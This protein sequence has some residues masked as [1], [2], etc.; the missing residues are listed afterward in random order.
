TT[1]KTRSTT[2]A[3]SVQREYRYWTSESQ[4]TLSCPFTTK[5]L[6]TVDLTR[7][8]RG[9]GWKALQ[10]I[11]GSTVVVLAQ[12]F[13]KNLGDPSATDRLPRGNI[14]GHPC[15]WD[16]PSHSFVSSPT[17]PSPRRRRDESHRSRSGQ[18]HRK[19]IGPPL[20]IVAMG[21]SVGA[22]PG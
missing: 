18:A 13:R 21:L 1:A 9:H 20:G 14:P 5:D 6:T 4:L 15:N 8:C 3:A 16:G 22:P 2:C 10:Q 12:L 17:V 7:S 19:R 11:G